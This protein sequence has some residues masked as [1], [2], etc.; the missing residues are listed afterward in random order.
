MLVVACVFL[1]V[2]KGYREE[3]VFRGARYHDLYIV[4]EPGTLTVPERHMKAA[5]RLLAKV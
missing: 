5:V 3:A 4:L 2:V 1:F